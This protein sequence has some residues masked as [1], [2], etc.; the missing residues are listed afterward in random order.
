MTNRERI[1]ELKKNR[2]LPAEEMRLLLTTLSE[3]EEKELYRTAC[4]VRNEIYGNKVYLRGLIEFSSYCKNDCRYCGLRRSNGQAKRYRLTEEE[5][6]F[7]AK[8]GYDLGFRTFV[9]QSGEDPFFTDERIVSIVSHLNREFPDCAVTLSIGEKTRESYEA[10][11]AAGADRYLLRHE[12]ADE[13]HYAYLHPAELSLEN[14]LRCL[15][16]L[17]EIGF[18][19]GM[20]MMVGSPGQTVEHI[21]KDLYCMKAFEPQMVG[22][23]PFIPHQDTPFANEPSGTLKDTLHLLSVIRLMLPHVLLPATTALGTIHPLGREM[24]LNAGAN[25]VMPNLSPK[26]VRKK[27]MLYDGKICTED[28]AEHCKNCME[29]RVKSVGLQVA[30][31]RGDYRK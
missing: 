14:R 28:E 9:L 4:A 25:V 2:T 11:F 12:T 15:S 19:T 13:A 22:I 27:Y 6:L 29:M 16:D 18:Q 26:D 30:V 5:I 31:S 17:K 3:D 21:L 1:T 10:Y 8:R 7:C 20:G 24:G 23:G